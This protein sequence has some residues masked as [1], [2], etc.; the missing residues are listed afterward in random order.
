MWVSGTLT[1]RAYVELRLVDSRRRSES[2]VALRIEVPWTQGESVASLR[3]LPVRRCPLPPLRAQ[4]VA[5]LAPCAR[6]AVPLS[7]ILV[8]MV[9]L[10]H[11][12]QRH[13]K[14]V[15]VTVTVPVGNSHLS[16]SPAA[17]IQDPG[18]RRTRPSVEMG[19][20]YWAQLPGRTA[21][22]LNLGCTVVWNGRGLE[23]T[24]EVGHSRGRRGSDR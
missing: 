10:M 17:Q 24:G 22:E 8:A 4:L 20:V 18:L 9:P 3:E 2:C 19:E 7:R 23:K 12:R 6:L 14:T 1:A 21:A 13:E 5:H 11:S 16:S 15:I